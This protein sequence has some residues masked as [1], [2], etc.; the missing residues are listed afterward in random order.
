MLFYLSYFLQQTSDSKEDIAY[1]VGLV[2]ICL[3]ILSFL[4]LSELW[5]K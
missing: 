1:T 4:W 5:E 2:V 3:L